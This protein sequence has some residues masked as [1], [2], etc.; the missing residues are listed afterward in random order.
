MIR[1][2]YR[3]YAEAGSGAIYANTFGANRYKAAGCGRERGRFGSVL[4]LHGSDA[5]YIPLS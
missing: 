4:Y 3:A 5:G 1:A 2:V